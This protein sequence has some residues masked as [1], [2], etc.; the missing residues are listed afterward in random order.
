MIKQFN[1]IIKINIDIDKNSPLILAVQCNKRIRSFLYVFTFYIYVPGG[2][3]IN[4][5]PVE[6]NLH[7][8]IQGSTLTTSLRKRNIN[9][10]IS[11]SRHS[12]KPKPEPVTIKT[13]NAIGIG[14]V[15][16][17]RIKIISYFIE[18]R[19]GQSLIGQNIFFR[20]TKFL[21]SITFTFTFTF[22]FLVTKNIGSP[23][24]RQTGPT[25]LSPDC[26]SN[27]IQ[28]IPLTINKI[29][30]WIIRH[31]EKPDRTCRHI[32]LRNPRDIHNITITGAWVSYRMD[33]LLGNYQLETDA[34][35]N[36]IPDILEVDSDEDG[37]PDLKESDLRLPSK[38]FVP[39]SGLLEAGGTVSVALEAVPPWVG[40]LLDMDRAFDKAYSGGMLLATVVIQGY[41]ADGTEVRSSEYHF[42]I[43]VCRGCLV[44]YDAPP[45]SCCNH[46]T[47]PTS[48]P[49]FP[50]QDEASS[51]SVACAVLEGTDRADLKV[52]MVKR[53]ISDL[54]ESLP[55][56]SSDE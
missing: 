27:S 51:C 48:V 12:G 43:R 53:E 50:G 3:G 36:G 44:L 31:S 42:P 2:I 46:S 10:I 21:T 7:T 32:N 1:L 55:V 30:F 49:C 28:R 25:V 34:D 56:I 19:P 14:T 4:Q 29:I 41:M 23:E 33:G 54:S 6:S 13:R 39:T 40:N 52:L 45:A 35:N 38:A 47:A 17:S 26:Q 9:N 16:K 15:H 22:T 8:R 11:P 5:R 20:Y 18:R 37:K 24:Y